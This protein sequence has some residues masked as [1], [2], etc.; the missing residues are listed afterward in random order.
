MKSNFF[1]LLFVLLA[2]LFSTCKKDISIPDPD[3][4]KLFGTWE[5]VQS[6]GGFSGQTTT[7]ASEGYTFTDK[8]KSNGVL[9]IYKNGNRTERMTYKF[10]EGTSILSNQPAYLIEYRDGT[11]SKK[12]VVSQLFKFAGEDTLYLFD[13]SDDGFTHIYVRK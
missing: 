8:Y 13:N 4:K 7:P 6:S 3:F 2:I 5:W 10:S 11:F 1:T 12:E 9:I